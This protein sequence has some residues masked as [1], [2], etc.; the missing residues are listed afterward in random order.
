M[1][2]LSWLF[3]PSEVDRMSRSSEAGRSKRRESSANDGSACGLYPYTG[4]D[5]G[6]SSS[7]CSSG[8]DAGGSCDGGGGGGG[9]GG[10]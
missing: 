7:H 5:S 3:G 2:L 1:G 6:V 8:F 9:G 10:D 4:G